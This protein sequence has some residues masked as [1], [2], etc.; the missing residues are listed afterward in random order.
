MKNR[1]GTRFFSEMVLASSP[2]GR[3]QGH[4]GHFWSHLWGGMGAARGGDRCL[5]E[6]TREMNHIFTLER[7]HDGRFVFQ[8]NVGEAPGRKDEA[9]SLK[10]RNGWDCT[11]ARLLQLCIPRRIL[12]VTGKETPKETHL[13]EKRIDTL[14]RAGR[15]GHGKEPRS[16]LTLAE[17]L[18]LLKDPLAPTRLLGASI[19]AERE[20]DCVDTLMDM[21]DSEDRFTRYGAAT[22]LGFVGFGRKEA[23]DRL[24]EMI[25]TDEDTEFRV[26]AVRA[27]TNT[28]PVLGLYSVARPAIPVLLRIAAAPAGKDDPRNVLQHDISQALFV[29][30]PGKERR[31]LVPKYG[32]EGIDRSLLVPAIRAILTNENGA[33]RSVA[34]KM[35]YPLLNDEER[36]QLWRDIYRAS[37]HIAPSGIMFAPGVRTDGL[38][39]MSDHKVEEGMDLAAWY[40]RWQKPHGSDK[41]AP[42][43]LEA[44]TG[45]GA[46]AQ[47]LI[48]YLESHVKD[49]GPGSKKGKAVLAAIE[50]IKAS[51]ERPELVS[52]AKHLK[53]GDYPPKDGP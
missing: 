46:H 25:E 6:F 12:H 9:F 7:Q 36:D 42:L 23:A 26:Y 22:A 1:K 41:R 19:L 47:A 29:G 43:A 28:D 51:T 45:Y 35:V 44:I 4:T 11:G 50:E 20:I 5:R 3:E 39:Y 17:V 30:E 32:F 49:F 27:L 10:S 8:N 31:G 53:E 24:I 15:L 33:A 16:Q 14:L 21:L 52:I 48:S 40:V 37:R 13:T 2:G 38:A 18:E 34:S